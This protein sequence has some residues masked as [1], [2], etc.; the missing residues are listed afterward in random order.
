MYK[1]FYLMQ[2][3]P[4]DSHPSPELFY[5]SDAHQTGWQ[6]LVNG[7]RTHEPILLVEGDYGAG[8]TLLYLKL[9][10]LFRKNSKLSSVFVSTPTYNFV[11]VLEKIVEKLLGISAQEIGSTDES[12]LQQLIYDYFENQTKGQS[13]FVYV[14]IDDVQE[15]SYAFV[16]KLRL[17]VS[18]NVAG[19][20]PIRLIMFSHH[21]FLKMLEYKKLVAFGQRIKRIYHLRSL[22]FEETREYIYFRLIYSGASGTPVF[23]DEA[24]QMIRGMSKGNPRLINNICD[25]C[26]LAASREKC[27][28]IDPVLVK[29]ALKNSGLPGIDVSEPSAPPIETR[30]KL[31]EQPQAQN[32]PQAQGHTPTSRMQPDL[33]PPQH[34]LGMQPGAQQV[35]GQSRPHAS[36]Q[37]AQIGNGGSRN[38]QA[39]QN[40]SPQFQAQPQPNQAPAPGHSGPKKSGATGKTKMPGLGQDSLKKG[41]VAILV[42][43]IIGLVLYLFNTSQ[44]KEKYDMQGNHMKTGQPFLSHYYDVD[45]NQIPGPVVLTEKFEKLPAM[46][47]EKSVD[48]FEPIIHMEKMM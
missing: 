23:D 27:N 33:K 8:K 9:V 31:Q 20:F 18:Y 44:T 24:I 7:I 30:N 43:I 4:F 35:P 36:L 25:N 40:I 38:Y 34:G 12:R 22:N 47:G 3:E 16:N 1:E 19:R 21:S 42:I 26:L 6:Y 29:R 5:K 15:F 14:V 39:P 41:I 45:D 46:A 32:P 10:R 17:F 28:L 11:M 37:Q 13:E 2:K 48:G